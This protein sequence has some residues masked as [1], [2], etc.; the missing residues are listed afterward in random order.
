VD[1]T[2][3]RS[4]DVIGRGKLQRFLGARPVRP[5]FGL[6]TGEHGARD[7]DDVRRCELVSHVNGDDTDVLLSGDGRLR[8]GTAR[9]RRTSVATIGTSLRSDP[10]DR[11]RRTG[12]ASARTANC[13]GRLT[14]SGGKG[15][16]RLALTVALLLYSCNSTPVSTT[17][18]D[19]KLTWTESTPDVTTFQV[20]RDSKLIATIAG[21]T[22]TY[23]D[24][25][26]PAG[27]HTYDVT[28]CIAADSVCSEVSNLAVA[29][30]P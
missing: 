30:V 10:R 8:S 13:D 5:E 9:D 22:D 20:F 23:T 11:G 18:Y 21:A 4:A 1:R 28:A 27:E 15:T 3:G 25:G 16:V 19:V 17:S 26:A 6:L 2:G 7:G 14:G 29:T 12:T 24:I